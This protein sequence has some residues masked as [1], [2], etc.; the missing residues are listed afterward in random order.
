[1]T[2]MT[3]EVSALILAVCLSVPFVRASE[4]AKVVPTIRIEI[5]KNGQEESPSDSKAAPSIPFGEEGIEAEPDEPD[6]AI[7]DEGE[8]RQGP[9]TVFYGDRDLPD[10]VRNLRNRL[11]EVAHSGDVEQLRPILDGFQEAPILSL[12]GENDPIEHL[13]A[14]SGDGQGIEMLA[15]LLEI[16]ESGYV[17]RDKGDNGEIYIWPYFVDIPPDKLTPRQLVELFRII[18]AGDFAD[19]QAY[20][21]YVFYRIGITPNGEMKFFIAGD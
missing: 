17:H 6:S 5:P 13:K 3:G 15:I 11:L 12:E 9:V 10:A 20:G 16:L 7:E 19:M 14:A 4:A 8:E 18:T 2:R 21:T 1:M